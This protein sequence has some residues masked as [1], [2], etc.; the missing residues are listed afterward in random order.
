MAHL[1]RRGAAS[2]G[3]I[4]QALDLSAATVRHHLS[5][6]LDDGRV[7]GAGERSNGRRGRPQKAFRLSERVLGEN[8]GMLSDMLLDEWL[9]GS[10]R[11]K[12]AAKVQILAEGLADRMGRTDPDLSSMKRVAELT[13]RLNELHYESGWEA[14]AQGPRLL[15]GHCPYAAIIDKHPELCLM[16]AGMLAL[17]MDADVEQVAKISQQPGG[18]AHCVF[19]LRQRIGS[20]RT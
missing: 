6:L 12:Q 2:A 17:Q 13:R 8:Q 16:D 15:F 11:A 4:G 20:R 7:V 19:S 5:L 9:A 14:G 10:S 3:Q 18:S 1:R